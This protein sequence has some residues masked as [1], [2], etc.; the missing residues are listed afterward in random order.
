MIRDVLACFWAVCCINSNWK[1]VAENWSSECN[2]PLRR[3]KPNDVDRSIVTDS[4]TYQGFGEIDWKIVILLVSQCDPLVRFLLIIERCPVRKLS[5]TFQPHLRKSLRWFRSPSRF[6]NSDRKLN[7]VVR[8]PEK[9]TFRH[10]R[11]N[12]FKNVIKT[13]RRNVEILIF[14]NFWQITHRCHSYL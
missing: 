9:V 6:L 11:V 12:M 1:I 10:I 2:R 7:F 13:L 3:V 14:G 4:K 8:G 5:Y